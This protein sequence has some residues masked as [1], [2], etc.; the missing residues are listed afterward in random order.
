VSSFN[1]R[2]GAVLPQ[3]VDYQGYQLSF[4][5]LFRNPSHIIDQRGTGT[6]ALTI[7]TAGGYVTDGWIVVPTGTSVAAQQVAAPSGATSLKALKITGASSVT[8]VIVK[9]RIESWQAMIAYAGAAGATLT[10]Q[11]KAYISGASGPYT[12]HLTVKYPTAQDNYAS[13]VTETNA[14][15]VALQ[16]VANATLVTLAYTFT[17]SSADVQNG[18][19]VAFDFGNNFGNSSYYVTVTD[20]D[21]RIT[22]NLTANQQTN[23]T[24]VPVPEFRP[25]PVEFAYNRLYYRTTYGNGVAPGSS[26][27]GGAVPAAYWA[28]A[29]APTPNAIIFDTPMRNGSSPSISTWDTAGNSAKASL[30]N[31]GGGA[32]TANN[33][34]IATYDVSA[35]G[36]LVYASSGS[37]TAGY[38]SIFHY[39]ASAE[40]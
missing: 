30:V 13:T 31:N 4:V 32:P 10:V 25:F 12:P 2:T 18:M 21:C 40:L 24:Y 17:V 39:S 7:T 23:S 38:M 20:F 11:A 5:N 14:S 36:F 3:P 37:G 27:I 28:S 6:T 33:N 9:Q 22:P 15:A 26:Q 35:S 19:E 16:S 34:G 1:T 29:P 8:D